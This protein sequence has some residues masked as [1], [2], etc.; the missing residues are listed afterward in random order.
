MLRAAGSG[1]ADPNI[2]QVIDRE[3]QQ[4][5]DDDG[6]FYDFLVFWRDDPPPGRIVD[7]GAEAKRLQENAALGRPVTEGATPTIER[8]K[9]ALFEGIF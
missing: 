1:A 3:S 4:I 8:K 9:K 5:T 6:Y 2:R 7:P